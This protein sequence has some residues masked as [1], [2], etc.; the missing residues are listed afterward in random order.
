MP[1]QF[2]A[3]GSAPTSD[4]PGIRDVRRFARAD[5]SFVV[6]G[7]PWRSYAVRSPRYPPS[8]VGRNGT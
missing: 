5:S 2:G 3:H 1:I 7:T 6:E 4:T 8:P